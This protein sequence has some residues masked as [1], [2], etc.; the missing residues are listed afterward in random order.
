M[1]RGGNILTIDDDT[2]TGLPPSM[3]SIPAGKLRAVRS[4]PGPEW[5]IVSRIFL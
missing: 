2:P 5:T 1:I 4:F 3:A